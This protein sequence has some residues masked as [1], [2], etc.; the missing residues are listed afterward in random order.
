ML[1]QRSPRRRR[2][3]S[4]MSKQI[5]ASNWNQDLSIGKLGEKLIR[6]YYAAKANPKH[7]DDW[8][9]SLDTGCQIEIKTDFYSRP[10]NFFFERY[11]NLNIRSSGAFTGGPFK[12]RHS[13]VFY[14]Y[15]FVDTDEIYWFPCAQL[16][17]RLESAQQGL[18]VRQAF[19]EGYASDGFVVSIRGC[20]HLARRDVLP[21]KLPAHLE[22]IRMQL[23]DAVA[24]REKRRK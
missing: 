13:A 6:E 8:D 2:P 4:P 5:K 16:S 10:R 24:S 3:T 21:A 11:C 14:V 15:Y 1:L 17:D 18:R 20:R 23:K 9:A 12:A 22:E 19:N 7:I